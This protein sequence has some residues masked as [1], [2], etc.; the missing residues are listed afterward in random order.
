MRVVVTGASGNLGT[1]VL[2]SLGRDP[3]VKEILG[4]ARRVP[5][6]DA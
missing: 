3:E 4:L 1:S 5:R 2:A 6:R